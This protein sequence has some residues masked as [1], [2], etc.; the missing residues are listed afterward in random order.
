MM[1][2]SICSHPDRLNI[3]RLIVGRCSERGIAG[4]YG[5]TDSTVHRHKRCI[6]ESLS[7]ASSQQTGRV[8]RSVTRLVEQLEEMAEEARTQKERLAFLMCAREL[9]PTLQLMGTV[10]GEVQ[11][12]TMRAILDNVG[13]RD[14]GEIRMAMGLVKSLESPRIEDYVDDAVTLLRDAM[15]QRP[16]LRNAVLGRLGHQNLASVSEVTDGE[17][18]A[19]RPILGPHR[20][21]NGSQ[22]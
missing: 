3:D 2:C 21:T 4:R 6:R 15:R 16:E 5:L 1:V 10:N 18:E 12:A 20:G 13:A 22:P 11:S 14:E 8:L 7:R 19:A 9:R 17:I